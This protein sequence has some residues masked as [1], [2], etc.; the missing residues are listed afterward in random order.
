MK[1]VSAC[2]LKRSR[3]GRTMAEG[4]ERGTFLKSLIT[5]RNA[6]SLTRRAASEFFNVFRGRISAVNEDGE[7]VS[8]RNVCLHLSFLF[9]VFANCKEKRPFDDIIFFFFFLATAR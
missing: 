6:D 9:V 4:N 7:I 5:S 3:T 2:R 8:F 1:G